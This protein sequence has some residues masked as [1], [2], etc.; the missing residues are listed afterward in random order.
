MSYTGYIRRATGQTVYAKP[1]P[2]TDS[3]WSTGVVACTE[4]GTLG[5]YSTDSAL[6]DHVPYE[7]FEQSGGS[8]AN[9]DTAFGRFPPRTTDTGPVWLDTTNGDTIANG[10][11]GTQGKPLTTV[12]DAVTQSAAN[13][14]RE[15]VIVSAGNG[16]LTLSAA[17]NAWYVRGTGFAENCSLSNSSQ[18]L[19]NSRFDNVDL[20]LTGTVG[21]IEAN[22][23]FIT[24]SSG[25]LKGVLR[26]CC[27]WD[28]LALAGDTVLANCHAR[29]TGALTIDFTSLGTQTLFAIG[30]K[31]EAGHVLA[32]L[33]TAGLVHLNVR[34]G[35][36]TINA[37]CTAGTIIVS[38]SPSAVTDNSGAGCTVTLL[39]VPDVNIA[40]VIGTAPTETNAGDLANNISQFFDVNPTTSK[41]VNDVGGGGTGTGARTITVT[42]NDGSDALENATVRFTEGANT[43]SGE[44]D[45]NG[46]LVFNLDDATYTVAIT[47]AGYTFSGTT[48]AVS[49]DAS[50]T[51]SMTAQSGD[52]TRGWL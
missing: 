19:G 1:L 49:A 14:S 16:D 3:P 28:D 2:L 13:G 42:V 51:Y 35:P 8:P 7:V 46:Q 21:D 44:T 23:C 50:P 32:N 25:T 33:A 29:K 41:D 47:K 39:T 17:L 45:S 43:Y 11:D 10:N 18:S 5:S 38:G 4:N 12:A 36:V 52:N 15:W 37:T 40:K 9:T 22:N 30:L 26:G 31:G 6:A 34:S 20:Q 27:L 24:Q 48:L